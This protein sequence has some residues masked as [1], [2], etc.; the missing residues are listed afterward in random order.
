MLNFELEIQHSGINREVCMIR[1]TSKQ[2]NF[3]R[4]GMAHPRGATDYPDDRFSENDLRILRSEPMLSV[5]VVDDGIIARSENPEGLTV[6]KLK[7]LLDALKI[8]YPSVAVKADL[9]ELLKKNT[10]PP[11][12][13]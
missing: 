2:H 13:E 4:C 8:Q 3:R 12:E 5:E 7:K 9:I 10:A 6:P 11:P 1:I